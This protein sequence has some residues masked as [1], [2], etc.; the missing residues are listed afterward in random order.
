MDTN[1][2]SEIAK[3]PDLSD[4]FSSF[5]TKNSLKVAVSGVQL[6]ELHEAHRIHEQ[7]SK[8]FI[9][10]DV[11]LL[12]NADQ[13]LELEVNSHPS[14]MTRPVSIGSFSSFRSGGDNPEAGLA[15]L[16]GASKIKAER[17][18]MS[19]YANQMSDLLRDRKTNFPPNKDGTYGSNQAE[20][21]AEGVIALQLADRAPNFM[22]RY[23]NCVS[24]LQT[25]VLQSLWLAPLV[26]FYKYYLSD[27]APKPSDLPDLAHLI[28][29]PYCSVYVT[30]RDI[31]SILGQ[32]KRR[33]DI[34][35][36]TSI[37][38]IDWLRTLQ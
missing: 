30:E 19:R 4:S 28:Y 12:L 33:I 3:N 32:I 36:Y 29:A 1:I 2:F 18:E 21:F 8:L 38:N 22:L 6:I 34:L 9:E 35:E 37:E 7:I 20:L 16:L 13:L 11:E 5:L 23:E 14:Y 15:K 10:L 27:R 17:D 25:K 31:C 24:K 26:S